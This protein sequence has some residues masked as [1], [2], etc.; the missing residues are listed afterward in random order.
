MQC[1]SVASRLV[2]ALCHADAPRSFAFPLRHIAPRCHSA[3][4][5]EFLPGESA[6]SAVPPLA[7]AGEPAIVQPFPDGFFMIVAKADHPELAG[8]ACGLG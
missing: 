2:A 7:D 4:L 1:Y 8:S 5:L 3:A 6:L